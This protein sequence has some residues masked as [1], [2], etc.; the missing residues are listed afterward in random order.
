MSVRDV[1]IPEGVEVGVPEERGHQPA[2][3]GEWNSVR[4]PDIINSEL[5]PKPRERRYRTKYA[6]PEKRSGYD[7]DHQKNS[8]PKRKGPRLKGEF[9]SRHRRIVSRV[10]NNYAEYQEA[11][12]EKM[13]Q[14]TSPKKARSLWFMTRLIATVFLW[15]AWLSATIYIGHS[16]WS[17]GGNPLYGLITIPYIFYILV[18]AMLGMWVDW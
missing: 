4:I 14:M 18:P 9:N 16:F 11:R 15:G 2:F 10:D 5:D 17:Q 8:K 6:P 12:R 1:N 3:D 7:S 13:P